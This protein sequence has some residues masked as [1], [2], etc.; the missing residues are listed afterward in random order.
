MEQI[1]VA[2]GHSLAQ[3]PVPAEWIGKSLAELEVRPRYK[4]NVVA[5]RREAAEDGRGDTTLADG[6]PSVGPILEMPLP[7]TK[8]S[9]GDI[10][11]VIGGDEHI[12]ALPR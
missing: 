2:D 5:I 1:P 9:A 7:H 8:L 11:V 3:V 4:V 12:A 6:Q 10:L